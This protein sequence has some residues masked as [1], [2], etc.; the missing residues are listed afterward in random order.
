MDYRTNNAW[1]RC[2]ELAVAVYRATRGFPREERLG[3]TK[4]V[5]DAAVSAAA[6]VAEGYGRRTMRDLLH[7]LYQA[8]GSLNEVE[9]FIHLARRLEYQDEARQA[10][11]VGMQSEAARALQGLIRYWEGQSAAGRAE[12]ARQPPGPRSPAPGP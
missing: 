4:Q 10:S 2:D 11:L 9:Y 7:F 8:R 6:N 1:Q 12:M 3:L 5:R